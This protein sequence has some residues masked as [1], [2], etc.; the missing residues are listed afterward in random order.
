MSFIGRR[1]PGDTNRCARFFSKGQFQ[2]ARGSVARDLPE[3][4]RDDFRVAS[5][6]EIAR[7]L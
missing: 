2:I 5:E 6:W 4:E 7:R 1:L 3:T